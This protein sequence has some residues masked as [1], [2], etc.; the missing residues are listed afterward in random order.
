M[1]PKSVRIY[2]HKKSTAL[3]HSPNKNVW[4]SLKD[5]NH[6]FRH[7]LRGEPY[8]LTNNNQGA[9]LGSGYNILAALSY[10]TGSS[11][12]T[13]LYDSY[14][15]VKAKHVFYPCAN[16][17]DMSG[18]DSLTNPAIFQPMFTAIDYDDMG[19]PTMSSLFEYASMKQHAYGKK[20]SISY[21]P[22]VNNIIDTGIA[23]TS[24]LKS[25]WIDCAN[26]TVIHY[27]I[28]CWQPDCGVGT[29][30]LWVVISEYDIEFRGQR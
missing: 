17:N 18:L 12:Y 28:K 1:P 3:R 7:I 11:Q 14:R 2:K 27:G 4:R 8:Y 19:T 10:A 22:H 24:S 20:F 6:V 25:P 5:P 15:I 21:T 29:N 9:G 26:P 30:N 13:A 23:A 16:V